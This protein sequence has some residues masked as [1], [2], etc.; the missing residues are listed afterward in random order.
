MFNARIF[1]VINHG[2]NWNVGV[3]LYSELETVLHCEVS[4]A[5]AIYCFG[6]KTNFISGLLDRKTI[7]IIQLGCLVLADI[8][9]PTIS[10]TFAC[11]NKSKHVC[12][13]R[14]AY[15]LAQWLNY[16]ILRTKYAKCL[17]QPGYNQ[18]F[19]DDAVAS[20][21]LLSQRA[22]E[23]VSPSTSIITTWSRKIRSI[24]LL[25]YW[26]YDLYRASMPVQGCTLPLTLPFFRVCFLRVAC[27]KQ[28]F[29]HCGL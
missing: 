29:N 24:L 23:K 10:C 3:V 26:P 6:Q 8:I 11:H 2:Y 12:A 18:C 16:Y 19:P 14:R 7:N 27:F 17:P 13:L 9:L 22:R 28:F 20:S 4:S 5:G 15:L 1:D 25:P 21:H